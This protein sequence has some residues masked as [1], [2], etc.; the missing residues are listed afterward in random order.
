MKDKIQIDNSYKK[1]NINTA[2]AEE[3]KNHPY[4]YK[5]NIANAIVNYRAKHG[6][7]K[8]ATDL[9][10]TDLVSEE[11]CRKIAPYLNFE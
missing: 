4:I 1:I 10:K 3:L 5:W 9:M 8:Q 11:L 7:Y 2:T 6:N